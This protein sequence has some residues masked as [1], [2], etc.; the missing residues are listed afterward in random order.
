MGKERARKNEKRRKEW[1]LR[2]EDGKRTERSLIG[3][4]REL[5][6]KRSEAV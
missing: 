3:S 1:R 5:G 6:S 4:E 2:V